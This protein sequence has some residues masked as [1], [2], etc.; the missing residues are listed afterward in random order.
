MVALGMYH[1]S[2]RFGKAV[3]ARLPRGTDLM[4]GLKQI[5]EADGIKYGAILA[6]IGSLQGVV[7]Q[8][9]DRETLLHVHGTFSDQYG[10]VYA[11]HVVTGENPVLTPLHGIVAGRADGK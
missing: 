3:P 2:G 7:F 9:E 10:K 5:C 8:S 1:A 6:G 4:N 11:G